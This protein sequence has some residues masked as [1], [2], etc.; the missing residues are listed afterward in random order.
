MRKR[1]DRKKKYGMVGQIYLYFTIVWLVF[2]KYVLKNICPSI[3]NQLYFVG[4]LP[5]PNCKRNNSVKKVEIYKIFYV[6]ISF[7]LSFKGHN[8]KMKE[9]LPE[10][11]FYF[12]LLANI[13]FIS[14]YWPCVTMPLY[15]IIS[16]LFSIYIKCIKENKH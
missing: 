10:F 15:I 6:C 14:N 16:L 8:L 3:L 4:L 2:Q 13:I 9:G 12:K 7:H 1:L 5:V 11:H